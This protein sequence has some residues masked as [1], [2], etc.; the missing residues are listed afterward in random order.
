M[1]R[2]GGRL[3]STIELSVSKCGILARAQ[4]A[5]LNRKIRFE[6]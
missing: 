4:H 5:L 1:H 2:L 6:T 3:F